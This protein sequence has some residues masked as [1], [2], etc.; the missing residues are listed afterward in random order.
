MRTVVLRR[1]LVALFAAAVSFGAITQAQAESLRIG[2]QKYGTLVL[3]KAKGSLEKRL[4][5]QGVQVQWTEFPAARSC[6]RASTWAP[7]TLA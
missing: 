2:Y 4:A 1:G 5:A 3:L 7:S 6:S